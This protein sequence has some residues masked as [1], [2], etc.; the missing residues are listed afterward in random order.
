MRALT[1][2]AIAVV[3][4]A[5]CSAAGEPELSLEPTSPAAVASASVPD[6]PDEALTV[7]IQNGDA[8]ALTAALERGADPNAE[9]GPDVTALVAAVRRDDAELVRLLAEAGA[10]V[11]ALGDNGFTPLHRAGEAAG[12]DVVTVLLEAG[13]LPD[14][15]TGGPYGFLPIQVAAFRNN[16][17]AIE[18]FVAFGVPVDMRNVFF[19]ATALHYAAFGDSVEAVEVLLELGADPQ[20][21]Q[22]DG[23]TPLMVA[24]LNGNARAAAILELVTG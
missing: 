19:D 21:L 13:A 3:F 17:E 23:H 4:L 2:T 10:D 20:A 18:A 8:A 14:A 22:L 5:G 1:V 11:N 6:D 16:P 7:A 12:G 9:I 15:E 24:Q